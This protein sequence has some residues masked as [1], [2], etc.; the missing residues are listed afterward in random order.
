MTYFISHKAILVE[1]FGCSI[2]SL[3]NNQ[4]IGRLNHPCLKFRE[5]VTLT[6]TSAGCPS[7]LSNS[8]WP[9]HTSTAM[10]S[11]LRRTVIKGTISGAVGEMTTP[12]V[13]S[14]K[15]MFS[16]ADTVKP[17]GVFSIISAMLIPLSAGFQNEELEEE[18]VKARW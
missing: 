2:E 3:I 18:N 4:G 14:P 16:F 11:S 12:E 7:G 15:I 13:L 5:V 10:L 9:T 17:L 8:T 6:S 1:S